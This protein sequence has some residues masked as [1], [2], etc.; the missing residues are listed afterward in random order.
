MLTLR[1]AGVAIAWWRKA[2]QGSTVNELHNSWAFSTSIKDIC[3][4][5]KFFNA[6]ALAALMTKF[7]IIDGMLYQKGTY[8][9]TDMA[10]E[11]NVTLDG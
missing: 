10:P 2:L 1:A 8:T 4:K 6:V 7:A 9:Y 11:K 3:L 5:N